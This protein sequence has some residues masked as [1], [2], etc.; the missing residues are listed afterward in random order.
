V[1]QPEQVLVFPEAV[2]AP[3]LP[4]FAGGVLTDRRTIPGVLGAALDP[5]AA[6]FYDRAAAETDP[7]YKQVIPYCVLWTEDDD[8]CRVFAYRRTPKGGEGRLHEKWSLG[9][10]GHVNPGDQTHPYADPY[11]AGLRRELREE[12]ALDLPEGDR[13]APAAA[14]IYDPSDE[15]GRVHFGVVHTVRLDPARAAAVRPADAALGA[16]RWVAADAL[17]W[18]AAHPDPGHPLARLESWSRLVA[19]HVR[20]PA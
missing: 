1:T 14:L 19:R 6:F 2:L 13:A 16:A 3:F 4:L 15:V 10:G 5:A 7:K 9:V 11:C 12:V 8:G 18:A 17:P 20:L